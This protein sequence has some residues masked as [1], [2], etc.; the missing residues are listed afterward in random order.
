VVRGGGAA[1]TAAASGERCTKVLWFEKLLLSFVPGRARRRLFCSAGAL[2]I[3]LHAAL[4]SRLMEPLM[5]II[6]TS[7]KLSTSVVAVRFFLSTALARR[8]TGR[9]YTSREGCDGVG[10]ALRKSISL[11][12]VSRAGL[13]LDI[14]TCDRRLLDVGPIISLI[15]HTM[16]TATT[17][18][19]LHAK[20]YTH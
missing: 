18:I 14:I 11:V 15:T 13:Q 5:K 19:A 7:L 12:I 16:Y 6:I 8:N 9:L 20:L 2:R 4:I 10:V 3:F 17:L 1:A